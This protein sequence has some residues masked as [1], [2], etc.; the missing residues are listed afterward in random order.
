MRYLL[1]N[2]LIL[3][4]V[5][6]SSTM[7]AVT[8][9]Y[10]IR[11]QGQN[12]ARDIAGLTNFI[13]L[14]VGECTT[15]GTVYGLF[16]YS[17]SFDS[18]AITDSL[19][20]CNL[21]KDRSCDKTIAVSGSQTSNRGSTDWLA[22]YFGLPTDFKSEMSFSPLIQNYVVD[23]GFYLGLDEWA[24]GLYLRVQVPITHTK[25]D[26]NMCEHI[27]NAG[28]NSYAPGYFSADTE[29][30]LVK[31]FTDYVTGSKAPTLFN[32]DY[33]LLS[34]AKMSAAPLL[35]TS[36][37][38]VRFMVG[39]NYIKENYYVGLNARFAAPV[40]IRPHG[41]FLF[42]PIVGNGHHWEF[43][44]GI[45]AYWNFWYSSC[46]DTKAAFYFDAN[47]THLFDA[48]QHRSF[49]L[50]NKPMS[51][52]M[53]AQKLGSDLG[54]PSLNTTTLPE[55]AFQNEFSPVANL[56]TFDVDVDVAIQG[57][58]VAM[59]NLTH[60][61]W[62]WD[63]GYNFWGRSCE[64][65]NKS[66]VP[67]PLNDG[68][69]WALKGDACVMGFENAAGFP[70][71]NLAAT[72]SQA[73]IHAGTNFAA[74][75]TTDA[76]VITAGR[77]NPNIDTATLAVSSNGNV[78]NINPSAS[79]QTRSSLTPVY[80][81]LDDVDIKG[82]RGIS[83]KLFTNLNYTW[84]EREDWTPYLGLGAEVEFGSNDAECAS[85]N[86]NSD[87]DCDDCHNC[88]ECALSQWGVW[89]KGGIA[90]N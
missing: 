71:V 80:I 7:F 69:T 9:Y 43:G 55:I 42:E 63:I 77:A 46:N 62:S 37:A 82:T 10:S 35:R 85:S 74:A 17:R 87:N 52:Y 83:N 84:L 68:Q 58:V 39:W 49:D 36:V 20:G 45:Q 32:V 27:T 57:E 59:F 6:L 34:N 70:V 4:L 22:D 61:H 1:K 31:N 23:L 64:R 48:R 11:S 66:G 78:V 5:T 29:S 44:G 26:L 65:F 72:E 12:S 56:T 76:A 3:A 79:V 16:Q 73:T 8:P 53:L 86:C 75:G 60:C 15:Y 2:I 19:F 51:R 33:V 88:Q 47:V 81:T 28:A 90:F 40:G 30:N 38:E 21:I 54:S 24:K 50:K 18:K 41:K 14:D 89:L 67:S 25:W 13:N